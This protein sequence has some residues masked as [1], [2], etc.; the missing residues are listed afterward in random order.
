M[1]QKTPTSCKDLTPTQRRLLWRACDQGVKP[2]DT[3][4]LNTKTA[5]DALAALHEHGLIHLVKSRKKRM[6]WKATDTG[7]GWA[8]ATGLHGVYLSRTSVPPYTTSTGCAMAGEPEAF[9]AEAA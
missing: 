3:K 1:T 8:A 9:W 5:R 4:V 2:D 6:V 7:R